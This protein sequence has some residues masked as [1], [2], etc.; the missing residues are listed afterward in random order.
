MSIRSVHTGVVLD[1][2]DPKRRGGLKVRVDTIAAGVPLGEDYIRPCFPL[3]GKGSGFFLIPKVG[4]I[5]EVEV[6]ADPDFAMGSLDA[7][8]RAA[9]Y[10][11]ADPIPAEFVTDYPNRGGVKFGDVVLLL[12]SG[13]DIFGVV[14]TQV[15]LGTEAATHPVIRGDTYNQQLDTFLSQLNTL[16]TNSVTQY[17][18]LAAASTGPLAPLAAGFGALATGWT[19]FAAAIAVFKGAAATW[20]STRV[21]TE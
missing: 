10:T 21:K 13:Q 1:N 19:T 7:A 4:S 6:E 2:K 3:A 14:S 8:W 11:E 20:L 9:L 17:G 12:D 18:V 15:R 5:V 16:A